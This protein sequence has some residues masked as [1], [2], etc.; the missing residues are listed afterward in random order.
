MKRTIII[1]FLIFAGIFNLF[2]QPWPKTYPQWSGSHMYGFFNSYDKGYMFLLGASY[3]D[4]KY[5][6]I[7]K[8]DING[9][10][11]WDKYI[12]NG[13]SFF[14][15]GQIDQTNDKGFIYCS[16][17]DKYDPTGSSDPF[18]IK[19]NPYGE[20][21]WCSV[22]N[23]PGIFDYARR[24]K[25]IPNGNYLM[26]TSY[27]DPNLVNRIQL[28]KISSTGDLLWKHNYPGDS[29]HFGEDGYDVMVINDG[30]LITGMCYSP[31]SGQ[32]GGGYERPYYIRTDTAGN[33]LWRLAYGRNNGYHGFPGFYTLISSSDNFYNVGWHS[34]YCDTP[35]INECLA[36]GTEGLF[37]DVLPGSCPGASSAINWLN[38]SV[39]VVFSFGNVSGNQLSKW[40]KLDSLGNEMYSKLFSSGW[41][42]S[43]F[44]N[45]VTQDK[46]I[47]A[48]SDPNLNL[49][50]YKLNQ[51]FDFDSIYTH[52]YTYDS[53]CPHP[54]VSDTIDPNCDLIVSI[55]DSKNNPQKCNL[56]VYPNPAAGLIRVELPK[57]LVINTGTGKYQSSKEYFQWK[58]TTLEV[59]DLQGRKVLEK[60]IPK[61][62]QQLEL[63]ISDWSRG[64]YY[65]RLVYDKQIIG[66]EKVVVK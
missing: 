64:L 12:G 51:N 62:Q 40:M 53:L 13:Q 38:D 21:D 39:F 8:I 42:S 24:I 14:R 35:A 23:T 33:E 19:F 9:N 48:L 11:L 2:S 57:T 25:Q 29:I 59:Y 49:Y 34:N 61:Q 58:S 16:G 18:M 55:D 60:E 15:I 17:F 26:L 22:I 30:Y 3:L 10:V 1:S 27:S 36:N 7:V 66:G 41:I 37:K 32:T 65:F 63:D 44:Y 5:S 6:I 4:Y 47:A 43:T 28:Y 50:F 54:I 52:S 20:M 46:K 31:D 45:V 56:K